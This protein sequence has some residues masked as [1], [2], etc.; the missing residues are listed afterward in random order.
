MAY[1]HLK[2]IAPRAN[3]PFDATDAENEAM[4]AHFAYWQEKAAA[5]LAVA[6]GPVF[7]PEGAW[8]MAIVETESEAD[9]Q[10][11]AKA[12]PVVQAN[13]GFRYAVASIPSLILRQ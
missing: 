13:L 3:F 6:V 10:A 2:L 12:D 1:F 11:L 5:K 8:G 9:A 4:N 7:D